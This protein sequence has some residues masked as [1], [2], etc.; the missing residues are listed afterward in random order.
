MSAAFKEYISK[1]LNTGKTQETPFKERL[2]EAKKKVE[3]SD[4]DRTMK[5]ELSNKKSSKFYK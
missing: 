5:R 2:N 1:E 4:K 3:V